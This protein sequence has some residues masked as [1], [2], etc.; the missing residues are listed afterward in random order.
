MRWLWCFVPLVFYLL[1]RSHGWDDF[2]SFSFALALDNFD[3]RLQQPQAPGFPVYI[4]LGQMSRALL[5]DAQTGFV[6]ISAVS[7]AASLWFIAEIGHHLTKARRTGYLTA[8]VLAVSPAVWVHSGIALSDMPGMAFALATTWAFTSALMY[9]QEHHYFLIGCVLA[10]FALGV[11]P[12]SLLPGGLAGVWA[13]VVLASARRWRL[14]GAGLLLGIIVVA[15]WLVPLLAESG[16][17]SS[18]MDALR[19]HAAHV[20]RADSMLGR[21]ETFSTRWD[22]FRD[23]WAWL[24]GS[25]SAV[26]ALGVGVIGV[27]VVGAG[28]RWRNHPQL[29]LFCGVWLVISAGRLFLYESLERPR[30]YLPT[31]YPLVLLAMCGWVSLGALRPRWRTIALVP[32]IILSIMLL[33]QSL[34]LAPLL[35]DTRSAPEQAIAWMT[36][37]YPP[38]STL[39]IA[40]GSFRAA[41]VLMADYTLLYTQQFNAEVWAEHIRTQSPRYIIIMDRDDITPQV[42]QQVINTA[43][44][45][46]ADRTFER[47][48]RVFP[49]H[50]NVRVQVFTPLDQLDAETLTLDTN[51]EIRAGTPEHGRYFG[52]GWFRAEDIGGTSARWAQ[53]QAALR[54]TLPA[55]LHRLTFR[56]TPFPDEQSV[57]VWVNDVWVDTVVLTGVW[58]TYSVT[59]PA[60]VLQGGEVNTV[61]LRHTR[62][63]TPPDDSRAIAAAYASFQFVPLDDPPN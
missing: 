32:P 49:Q 62:A 9:R 1:F 11:R 35:R 23:G 43:Y 36:P 47:E 4:W 15:L 51:G 10:G 26:F 29:I 54:L 21:G 58:N 39:V 61:I 25:S 17:I 45:P 59:I 57:A 3:I 16:G 33:I 63:E 46:L 52:E 48:R 56:V 44:V 30:L 38:E 19:D 41:Q 31:L 14:I 40:Q 8:L 5:G 20:N 55:V 22:A 60:E 27:G 2:D 24:V 12:Q 28:W 37:V 6:I 34:T 18:Y 53:E 7:G 13:L 42:I 50:V